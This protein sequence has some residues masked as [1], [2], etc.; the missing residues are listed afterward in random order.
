[1]LQDVGDGSYRVAM[2]KGYFGSYTEDDMFIVIDDD[3]EAAGT[4]LVEEDIID[5]AGTILQPCSYTTIF[6]A[7]RTIPMVSVE[8]IKMVKSR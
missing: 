4:R 8:W 7:T 2:G 5:F 3:G 1:M 6:G